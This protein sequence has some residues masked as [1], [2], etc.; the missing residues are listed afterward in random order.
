M[1]LLKDSGRIFIIDYW[2]ISYSINI[3]STW[4][5]F[6]MF[7]RTEKASNYFSEILEDLKCDPDTRAYLSGVFKQYLVATNDLSTKS[8]TL[9]YAKARERQSF[10]DFQIIGDWLFFSSSLFPQSLNSASI[11][12]YDTLA[13]ASYYRCYKLLNKKWILFEELADNYQNLVRQTNQLIISIITS[14]QKKF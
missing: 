5:W 9:L 3:H 13:R 4:S 8:I 1:K 12:Y 10:Q 14:D 6:R 11:E 7:I 2:I